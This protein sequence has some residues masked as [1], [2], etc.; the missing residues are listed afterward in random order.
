MQ[1][2]PYGLP[3]QPTNHQQNQQNT[4]NSNATLRRRSHSKRSNARNGSYN[5]HAQSDSL[6]DSHKDSR[7]RHIDPINDNG[8]AYYHGKELTDTQDPNYMPLVPFFVLDVCGTAHGDNDINN[9]ANDILSDDAK[10]V[11]CGDILHG[12]ILVLH[13]GHLEL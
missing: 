3:R 2:H 11:T 6:G 4:V 1:H 13:D 10:F 9:M 5:T 7:R 8:G 12:L